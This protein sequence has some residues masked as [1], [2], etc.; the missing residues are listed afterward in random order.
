ML[1][2]A[3]GS[4]DQLELGLPTNRELETNH[5]SGCIAFSS[6]SDDFSK[7]RLLPERHRVGSG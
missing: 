2:S 6:C 4:D 1:V 3:G 5:R 7:V